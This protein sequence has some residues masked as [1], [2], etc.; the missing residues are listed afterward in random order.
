MYTKL[1]NFCHILI[2]YWSFVCLIHKEIFQSLWLEFVNGAGQSGRRFV[3]ADIEQL[4]ITGQLGIRWLFGNFM[5]MMINAEFVDD[6]ADDPGLM[7]ISIE[8]AMMLIL[9]ILMMIIII[10]SLS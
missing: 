9:I 3:F 4:E 1:S 5:V 10:V 2:W 8:L 6:D 7:I